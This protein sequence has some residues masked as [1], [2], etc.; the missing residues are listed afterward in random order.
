MSIAPTFAKYLAS[1]NIAYDVVT[2]QPAM[3]SSRA[4]EASRIS[5]DRIAK[6]VVLR[7]ANGFILAILP[8]SRHIRLKDLETRLGFDVD[9][10]TGQE[11]EQLFEDCAR[12]AVPPAGE[13]YGL[14]VIVDDSIEAQ[15]DVYL[16]GGDHTTLIHLSHAQFERLTQ[17]AWRGHF[18]VHD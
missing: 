8:A 9:L 6:A 10:A 2:H 14:D 12:G 4:A 18:S 16:E 5:G 11:V 1:Q 17:K 13:C 7:D 3:S 15:P